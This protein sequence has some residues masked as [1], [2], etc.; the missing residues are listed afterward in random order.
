MADDSKKNS[1][2]VDD[3]VDGIVDD[4]GIEDQQVPE[5]TKDDP[6]AGLGGVFNIPTSSKRRK[7][8]SSTKSSESE[9]SGEEEL[10]KK[11]RL[12][13]KLK[14]E[15]AATSEESV[16]D[17]PEEE[18]VAEEPKEEPKKEAPKAK[19]SSSKKDSSSDAKEI[20]GIFT[21]SA[22]DDAPLDY[23]S[24]YLDEDDLGGH[25]KSGTNMVLVGII[26]IL[27]AVLGGVVVQF[28]D[29][30]DDL[31]ALF[32]GELREKRQAEVAKE[33]ADFK[34][35]QLAKMEKFGTL[36]VTG[37]P[38]HSLVKLNGEVQ[39]APTSSGTWRELR[40][41]SASG[42]TFRNL[43]IKQPQTVELSLPGYK[44]DSF[45]LTE[46]M[47]DGSEESGTYTKRI[48]LDL[49]PESLA[50]QAEMEKRMDTSDTDG[51][52]YGT[53]TINTIPAGAQIIFNNHPLVD[54]KGEPLVS[55]VTFS[56]Y[57]VKNEK[58]NK[59]E[60]K[61]I[62]VDTPP[63]V[64]HKIELKIP[65]EVGE[66]VPFATPVQRQMWTCEWKDG[67]APDAPAKGKSFRDYCDYKFSFDMD[68][69]GLKTYI[70]RREAEKERIRLKNEKMAAEVEAFNAAAAEKAAK[71]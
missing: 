7:K 17:E 53:I 40:V 60:K 1:Q 5:E 62:N 57:Y 51:D 15:S 4:L 63:D 33:E 30:G 19:K 21:P 43:K 64:G 54:K 25:K 49:V 68:F 50:N 59:L 13:K 23:S 61:E 26:L 39:Y 10:S 44:P 71:K 35:A 46:G 22:T 29:L 48:T 37:S 31:G 9:D 6:M 70:E 41:S 45:E 47:W 3:I 52:Y 42:T 67:S 69:K 8:K 65:E 27:L 58:T 28:T 32:R 20:A 16:K 36:N 11:E 56:E 18:A 14:E 34:A 12:R 24:D 66:F 2:S 38:M 55:P